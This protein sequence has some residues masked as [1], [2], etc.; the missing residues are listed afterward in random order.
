[1]IT[2]ISIVFIMLFLLTS[3]C[4]CN[5]VIKVTTPEEFVKAIGPDR[6][7]EMSPGEYNL[8]TLKQSHMD[9]IVWRQAFDG[10][11]LVVRKIKNLKIVGLGEERVKIIVEPRYV[12]VLNFE[13]VEGIELQN[14][15]LGHSPEGYCTGG[16]INV[17]KSKNIKIKNCDLYGCGTEGLTLTETEKVSFESSVI[18]DCSYGIMSVISSKYL[19]FKDSTFKNNREFYGFSINDCLDVKFENCIVKENYI[20]P[21]TKEDSCL[22]NITSSSKIV[23][24]GGEISNN[25][26]YTLLKPSGSAKVINVTQTGNTKP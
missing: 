26:Y 8:S 24:K 4:F 19:L 21:F 15:E 10:Y 20:G 17:N 9:Y 18:R 5:E 11:D 2:R 6:V 12:Y 13:N 7:I 16:V 14:L 3:Y 23:I 25:T 22:F 1:M